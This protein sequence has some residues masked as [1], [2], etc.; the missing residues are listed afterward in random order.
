VNALEIPTELHRIPISELRPRLAKLRPFIRAGKLQLV[1]TC[2]GEI[3]GCLTSPEAIA[4]LLE[5]DGLDV[6]EMPLTRFRDHLHSARDMMILGCDV[7]QLTFHRQIELVLVNSKH[8][9]ALEVAA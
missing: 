6:Q 9:D 2:Y 3:I 1:I 8:L 7:I 5:R 4:Q